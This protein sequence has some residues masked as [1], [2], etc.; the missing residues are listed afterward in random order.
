MTNYYG[1]HPSLIDTVGQLFYSSSRGPYRDGRIKPDNYQHRSQVLTTGSSV[2]TEWL[3]QPGCSKLYVA[4]RHA[5]SAKRNLVRITCSNR[6][7]CVVSAKKS[8]Q[9]DWVRSTMP[10]SAMHVATAGQEMPC[11]TITGGYGKVDA[12]RTLTGSWG[13]DS[14]NYVDPPAGLTAADIT[15]ISVA[16]EWSLIPNASGL[17]DRLCTCSRRKQFRKK[18]PV[19]SKT[20]GGLLPG[21]TYSCKVRAACPDFG[22]SS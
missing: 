19:N 4:R 5:L 6:N 2:P 11:Q 12:F 13:C 17:P 22:F 18:S 20:I 14:S 10:Y 7:C 15:P 16:L 8:C 1:E 21:T 9:A 3:Y